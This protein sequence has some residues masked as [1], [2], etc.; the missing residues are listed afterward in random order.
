V[1]G[2][3]FVLHNAIVHVSGLLKV[4]VFILTVFPSFNSG[5]HFLRV[6]VVGPSSFDLVQDILQSLLRSLVSMDLP[7][8]G[9]V[10]CFDEVCSGFQG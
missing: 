10:L 8:L 6:R 9:L 7:Q 3:W 1:S 5:H 2:A 4:I